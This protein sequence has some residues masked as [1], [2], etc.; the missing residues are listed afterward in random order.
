MFISDVLKYSPD[1]PK[2]D[3]IFKIQNVAD[4][5]Y[6]VD[7]TGAISVRDLVCA[8]PPFE[9]TWFEYNIP[10]MMRI[11]DEIRHVP[12]SGKIGVFAQMRQIKGDK[13]EV[14]FIL[15]TNIPNMHWKGGTQITC[16]NKGKVLID[17]NQLLAT[18]PTY[19][20]IPEFKNVTQQQKTEFIML[21]I[22]VVFY[23]LNF[24][25]C[26]NVK[27][28]ENKFD[29][30]LINNW[31]KKNRPF[32]EKYYTLEIDAMKKVLEDE[33]DIK[34]SGIKKALHICRGHFKNYDD[35]PLFG[36]HTGMYWWQHSVRGSK[37]VGII[38]K[39]YQVNI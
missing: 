11:G 35:K 4:Y 39:T 28:I 26:R 9:V 12:Y 38:N 14:A 7:P 15:F 32:F 25:H 3:A 24:L 37:D 18:N 36:K 21:D 16:D 6:K 1:M 10:N 30:K 17:E 22:N 5:Y 13:C 2:P 19:N 20:L 31:K 8:F 33:G 27:S 29:D 23:A 34:N